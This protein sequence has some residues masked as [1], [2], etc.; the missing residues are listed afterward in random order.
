MKDRPQ[1]KYADLPFGGQ[2]AVLVWHKYRWSCP[3]GDS[4]WTEHRPDIA[5]RFSSAMTWRAAVWAT[6]AVGRDL[7]PVSQVAA[8]LDV[9]WTTVMDVITV[10][11]AVMIDDPNRVGVVEQLGVDE[12]VFR[13]AVRDR[14]GQF[15]SSVTGVEARQVVDVFRGRQ[16]GDLVEWFDKQP[17]AGPMACASSSLTSTNRSAKRSPKCVPDA[18][19]VADPMHVVM[20]AN[21]CPDK[22]RRGVQQEQLEHRGRLANRCLALGNC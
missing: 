1:T 19:Q 6:I 12:T 21:R 3:G 2:R 15:V 11:G 10:V 22:T 4:T 20:A 8:E 13:S 7:R 9:A 5:A 17:Q 16:R 14:R 18:V